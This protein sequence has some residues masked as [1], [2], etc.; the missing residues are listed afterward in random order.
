MI[1]ESTEALK[2]S[3]EGYEMTVQQLPS[4]G[5]FTI[6]FNLPGPVDPRVCSP[7][8]RADGI[9][10]A[11]VMKHVATEGLRDNWYKAPSMKVEL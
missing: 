6:T 2:D 1:T 9:F 8:F 5:P 3:P 7:E 4:P 11:I 10:E